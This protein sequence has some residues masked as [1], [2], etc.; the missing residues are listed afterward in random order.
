MA[1][2]H[3]GAKLGPTVAE[4][5]CL[6]D[7]PGEDVVGL[8]KIAGQAEGA[9]KHDLHGRV[10]GRLAHEQIARPP[11]KRRGRSRLFTVDR[12]LAGMPQEAA[13]PNRELVVAAAELDPEAVRLLEVVADGLVVRGQVGLPALEPVGESY[14]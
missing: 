7:R 12:G 11:Q 5:A 2:L 14:V 3:R 9:T 4:L 13:G 8:R 1:A 6:L 10:L